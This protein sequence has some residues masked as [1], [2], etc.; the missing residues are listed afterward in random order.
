MALRMGA[1]STGRFS[2]HMIHLRWLPF[3][4][5]ILGLLLVVP[6][7]GCDDDDCPACPHSNDLAAPRGLYSITGN[8]FVTLVWYAN[9]EA[10]LD[11]YAI[12][13]SEAYDGEYDLIDTIDPCNDCYMEEVEVEAP[14]GVTFFYAVAAIDRRGNE[15]ELSIEEVDDTPRPQ[16]DAVIGN[17][18]DNVDNAGFDLSQADVVDA[19]N[20][21]ADFYYFFDQDGGLIIA[22]SAAPGADPT[23]IQDM[24]FTSNFDEIDM[25]P[26]DGWSPLQA[27]EAIEGHCYVILTRNNHY[28]KIRV[29]HVGSSTLAFDWAYQTGLGN[30]ELRHPV[31]P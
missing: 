20:P 27:V 5:A 7:W 9:T 30:R 18:D 16:G 26:P 28:A 14:N 15:S 17:A 8:E 4:I 21:S 29:T 22:G 2:P 12:Y 13:R 31:V 23:E 3:G 19:D 24:G 11:G 6:L 25:A 10:D 1:S